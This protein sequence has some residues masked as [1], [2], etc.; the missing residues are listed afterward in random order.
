VSL[1]ARPREASALEGLRGRRIGALI[2]TDGPGGAERIFSLLCRFLSDS[3]VEV[4]AFVP[5]DADG[6]LDR[7]LA[8]LTVHHYPLRNSSIPLPDLLAVAFRQHRVEM[9]H[10]HMSRAIANGAA[11]SSTASL[12]HVVTIH[13]AEHADYSPEKK[14]ALGVACRASS[15]TVVVSSPLAEIV[16]KDLE[17]TSEMVHVI[18]NGVALGPQSDSTLRDEIGLETDVSLILNVGNLYPVKGQRDL[19]HALALLAE[20]RPSL[21]LAV[22][23][24]G[25]MDGELVALSRKLGVAGRVHWLGL[26]SDIAN[27]LAAADV[28]ALSSLSEGHPLSLLEA[29]TAARPIVATDVGAVRE[30]LEEGRCGLLVPPSSPV[31]MAE[32]IDRLL[33][34]PAEAARLAERAAR[35]AASRYR[36]EIMVERYAE[37]YARVLGPVLAASPSG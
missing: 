3:G 13:G 35:R 23:G 9:I 27:L 4:V 7:E 14:R 2:G 8:S 1:T 36:A 19:L 30:T 32:A 37:L 11:A 22:A 12:P 33:S 15:G 28:F 6:W 25:G 34:K 26:R 17:L 31:R 16:R 24:R 29:M 5:A 18:P 10:S 21:H 20:R